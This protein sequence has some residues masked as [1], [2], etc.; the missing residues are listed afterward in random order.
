MLSETFEDGIEYPIGMLAS[1]DSNLEPIKIYFQHYHSFAQAKQKWAE[2][3]Q[4]INFENICMIF[5]YSAV[6]D[7]DNQ[8]RT[9]FDVAPY[10]HKV[11]VTAQSSAAGENIVHLPVYSKADYA[12]GMVFNTK[13]KLSLVRWL[14][15]FNYV[16]FLNAARGKYFSDYI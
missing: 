6:A 13:T 3:E 14:D 16:A 11:M 8:V 15:D 10:T 5:E 9:L 4:R 12:P 7:S 2:R 1:S